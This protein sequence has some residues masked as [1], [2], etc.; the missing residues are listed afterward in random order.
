MGRLELRVLRRGHCEGGGRSRPHRRPRQQCGH[1]PRRDVPQDDAGPVGRR[2]QHQPHRPLQHDP[3]G[4]DRHARPQFRPRHQH[5]LDQRPEGP[6]GPGELLRCQGRR[7]RLH[8]GACPGGR[9]QGHHGQRHLPRL[10]RH[11]NGA[12]HPGKGA[13]RANHPA[14]SRR[15]SRRAGGDR[16]RRRL[17]RLGRRRLHHRLDNLGQWRPSSSSEAVNQKE[18]G[19][20]GRRFHEKKEQRP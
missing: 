8:Q 19:A 1:H 4:L 13:E 9:G 12:R 6:D 5:F 17:P 7:S 2:H 15:P 10:Y 11:R 16:P 18:H 3:S 14:D 20:F